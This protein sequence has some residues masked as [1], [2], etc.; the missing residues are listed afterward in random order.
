M[1][2]KIILKTEMKM[3]K[4]KIKREW[5]INKTKEFFYKKNSFSALLWLFSHFFFTSS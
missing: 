1:H 4:F 5:Y 3:R 2:K